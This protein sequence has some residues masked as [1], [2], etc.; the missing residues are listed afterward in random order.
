MENRTHKGNRAA[1]RW[2]VL[3]P[4]IAGFAALGIGAAAFGTAGA[5]DRGSGSRLVPV[6]QTTGEDGPND[7]DPAADDDEELTEGGSSDSDSST[8]RGGSAGSLTGGS[9]VTGLTQDLGLDSA[10]IISQDLDDDEEEFVVFAF[11]DFVREI[12]DEDGFKLVGPA[13]DSDVSADSARLVEDSPDEVLVA[14]PAGT[15]LTQYSIATVDP[16]AV[17]D[18]VGEGNV[19]ATVTIDG[20]TLDGGRSAGPDL[21]SVSL[22]RTLDRVTYRFDEEL[23]ESGAG[24]ASDFGFY[25]FD[26]KVVEGDRVIT[27]E[28]DRVVV[29]FDDQVEDGVRF[30]AA[31]GAVDDRQGVDSVPGSIGDE[32]TSPDLESV[33]RVDGD[34]QFDFVFSEDVA[35]VDP[36]NFAVYGDDG[37][38]FAGEDWARVDA[39][40]VRVIFPEI[41]DFTDDIVVAAVDES[42]IEAN[43]GSDVSNTVGS[44]TVNDGQ[45]QS[46]ITSG[47]DLE[48]VQV[49]ESSGQVMYEFDEDVDDDVTYEADDFFVITRAGDLVPG[50]AFVEA[51]DDTILVTFDKNVVEAAD[52]FV[53][54]AGAAQDHAGNESP[55]GSL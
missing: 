44:E 5:I 6:Q 39:Q 24:S 45:I 16:D 41:D 26:G 8:D 33:S 43:D 54:N 46:G 35:N 47:P 53:I 38:R 3:R 21:V 1:N 42:A 10:R 55:A 30:F 29:E 20:S 22:D 25:T 51:E 7:I 17:R 4:W 2:K 12:N 34:T 52:G 48:S 36:A 32:T 28:D 40:T 11:E 14:F 49:D 19:P 15:D 18:E 37:T 27:I 13:T 50:R 9:R 23:N 31:G